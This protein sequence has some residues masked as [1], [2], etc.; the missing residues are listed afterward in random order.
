MTSLGNS[1]NLD[2]V[3]C[4]L[5]CILKFSDS[6]SENWQYWVLLEKWIYVRIGYGAVRVNFAIYWS[7]T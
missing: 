5:Q 2:N 6:E 7:T 4:R 3:T 1:W